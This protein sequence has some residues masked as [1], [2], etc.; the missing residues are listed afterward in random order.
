MDGYKPANEAKLIQFLHKE[1]HKICQK[2][3]ERL[4]ESM[5]WCTSYSTKCWFLNC[6]KVQTHKHCVLKGAIYSGCSFSFF[7]SIL[8]DE[9]DNFYVIDQGEVDVSKLA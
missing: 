4:V 5:P 3:G 2:Q 7:L 1:W 6:S 9:G 8:G